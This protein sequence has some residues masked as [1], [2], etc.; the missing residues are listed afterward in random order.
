MLM[1]NA[2]V[3]SQEREQVMVCARAAHRVAPIVAQ[4][5]SADKNAVLL[6][7]ASA[8]EEASAEIIAA[9][10]R[11]IDQGRARGLSEA[12]ID[13][14][15][16]DSARIAGIASGLRQVAALSD[17]VGGGCRRQRHAQWYADA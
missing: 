6:A 7:T 8:L 3:R 17:P 11:D 14:L 15:S 12:L 13:R 2:D 4:L 10:Q 1:N 5:T 9:N 16:L